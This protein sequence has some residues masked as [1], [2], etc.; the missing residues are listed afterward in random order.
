MQEIINVIY[1]ELEIMTLTLVCLI[2]YRKLILL[3]IGINEQI[4]NVLSLKPKIF[5]NF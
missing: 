5:M 4:V 2:I 3:V 1:N